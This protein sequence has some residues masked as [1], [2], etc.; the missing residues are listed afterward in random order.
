LKSRRETAGIFAFAP[1]LAIG[2]RRAVAKASNVA[3]L[4]FR[5]G[6]NCSLRSLH[7]D[8]AWRALQVRLIL[9]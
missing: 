3:G 6:F 7:N 2:W 1:P 4:P 8:D 5:Q 9:Q